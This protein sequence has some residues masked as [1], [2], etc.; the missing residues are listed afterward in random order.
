[1]T[2]L[3]VVRRLANTNRVTCDDPTRAVVVA[4]LPRV[5]RRD[6]FRRARVSGRSQPMR[7]A[8]CRPAAGLPHARDEASLTATHQSRYDLRQVLDRTQLRS[9]ATPFSDL[10][11]LVLCA[12]TSTSHPRIRAYSGPDAASY[13][14]CPR[15]FRRLVMSLPPLQRPMRDNSLMTAD[16]SGR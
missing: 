16:R 7:L 1:M 12:H 2:E 4:G 3:V 13:E 5:S 8:P 14:Y 9:A 6:L 15:L 10:H 11:L